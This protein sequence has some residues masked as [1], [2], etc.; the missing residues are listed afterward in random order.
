MWKSFQI[1]WKC[2]ILE[3]FSQTIPKSWHFILKVIKQSQAYQKTA[4]FPKIEDFSKFLENIQWIEA[5]LLLFSV[6]I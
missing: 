6:H 2:N 3:K 1:F 4:S 5:D